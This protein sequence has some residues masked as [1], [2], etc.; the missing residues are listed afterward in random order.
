MAEA[1]ALGEASVLDAT[2]E[3]DVFDDLHAK[4]FEAADLLVGFAAEEV[5]GADAKSVA[6]CFW[7]GDAP[8]AGGP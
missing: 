7:V 4:G 2:G 3:A 6:F 5:E 1:D 8:G